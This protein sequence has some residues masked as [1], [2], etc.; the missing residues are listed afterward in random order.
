[1]NIESFYN[2]LVTLFEKNSLEQVKDYLEISLK[3]AR[4]KKVSS[5]SLLIQNELL[6]FYKSVGVEDKAEQ[7]GKDILEQYK[8]SLPKLEEELMKKEY[9]LLSIYTTIS[10]L[11]TNREEYDAAGKLI[12]KSIDVLEKYKDTEN[13]IASAYTNLTVNCLRSNNVNLAEEYIRKAISLYEQ[14]D[15]KL[16]GYGIAL[17]GLAEVYYIKKE[18]INAIATYKGALDEIRKFYGE[19]QIYTNALEN[20]AKICYEAGYGEDAQTLLEHAQSIFSK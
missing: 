16:E 6:G 3:D 2:E 1:M 11:H 15:K 14:M 17:S 7:L 19:T 9:Y 8:E 18:Y 13:E 20:C 10:N 5:I 12:L 4:E